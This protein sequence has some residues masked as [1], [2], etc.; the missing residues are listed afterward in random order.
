MRR[1][2]RSIPRHVEQPALRRHDHADGQP[3]NG[4]PS[5]VRVPILGGCAA[6][7]L[8]NFGLPVADLQI[9]KSDDPDPVTAGETL[10]YTS[11]S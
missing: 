2:R 8:V 3:V 1:R 4:S 11:R 6:S 7:M 9:F 10:E 5:G